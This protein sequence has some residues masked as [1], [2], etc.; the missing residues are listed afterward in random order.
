MTGIWPTCRG[1][2][3]GS[4]GDPTSLAV[5]GDGGLW[6]AWFGQSA[7][8]R[9]DT[10]GLI[11]GVT[12]EPEVILTMPVDVLLTSLALDEAGGLWFPGS[13]G[14]IGRLGPEELGLSAALSGARLS[15]I[16]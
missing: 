14:E 16:C 10:A 15:L 2:V 1:Q 13:A 6:V 5:D 8:T 9:I 4:F 7:I 12:V 3:S 11:D